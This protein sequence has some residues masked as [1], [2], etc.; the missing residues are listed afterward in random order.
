VSWLPL[1]AQALEKLQSFIALSALRQIFHKL[2]NFYHFSTVTMAVVV[3]KREEDHKG[4]EYVIKPDSASAPAVDDSQWPLLLK[5]YT[6]REFHN[7]PLSVCIL[8]ENSSRT[9]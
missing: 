9:N 1:L 8:T 5:N 2:L 7:E 3:G 6:K 4:A